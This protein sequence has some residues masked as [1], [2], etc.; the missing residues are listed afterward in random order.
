MQR[1]LRACIVHT[2]GAMV[3]LLTDAGPDEAGGAEVQWRLI[4][5]FLREQDWD[6]SFITASFGQD[7]QIT[8][9]EGITV[10]PAFHAGAGLPLLRILTHYLPTLSRAM[11]TADADIYL[12]QGASWSAAPMASFCRANGRRFVFWLASHTDAVLSGPGRVR[13]PLKDRWLYRR[14]LRRADLVIAQTQ[15]QASLLERGA[16][17]SSVVIPNVWPTMCEPLPPKP[18]PPLVLWAA[19]N[20]PLKRP[21]MALDVA[22]RLPHIRFRLIGGASAD[23]SALFESVQSRAHS[24]ANVE[25]VGFVPFHQ[26]DAHYQEASVLLCT[27]TVE[28]FPNTFLQAWDA[29]AA[30]VST[31]DPDEVLCKHQVGFHRSDVDGI[32]DAIRA[33]ADDAS[34][35]ADVAARARAHLESRHSPEVVISR[36]DAAL[37]RLVASADGH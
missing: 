26:T 25:V 12:L 31:Y 4:A 10:I 9:A 24:I 1:S 11:S 17:L 8:T 37:R 34:L 32:V 21:H 36:L 22:E 20:I 30:V 6:V 29:G 28:G 16:G 19:R 18:D 23:H 27:S 2:S 15:E 35:Q 7:Q 3:R 13:L 5:R 14:G 33:L